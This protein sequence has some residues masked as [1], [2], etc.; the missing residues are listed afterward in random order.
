MNSDRLAPPP[1]RL[2][3]PVRHDAAKRQLE[4]VAAQRFRRFAGRWRLGA[5]AGLGIGLSVGGGVALASGVFSQQQ[6]GA[7]RQ[8][9]LAATVT[10]TRT[11]TATVYLG[12]PPY[13][14]NSV[15]LTLT[16]LNA[17][18]FRFPN[19]SSMGCSKSDVTSRN[20]CQSMEVE[21]LLPGKQSITISTSA[22]ATWTLEA[23]YVKEVVTP[24]ATNARGETY[25]VPNA[26]GFPDLVA[27]VFNDGKGQ[28]YAKWR[29]LN[30]AQ[31]G[32]G[33]PSTPAEAL[34]Q[35]KQRENTNVAVPVYKSDGT[36][37]IGVFLVG[38]RGPSTHTVPVASVKCSGPS[39]PQS[40]PISGLPGG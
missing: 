26:H 28:G 5:V 3:P 36:T 37:K 13:K 4:E 21:N 27:V 15:S 24:W 38:N 10:A 20:G 9:N 12:R 23:T 19:G 40:H 25:G 33:P 34:A 32:P 39:I 22:H 1:E 11:G 8:T 29:D 35:Q 16:G 31:E 17:G 14:A 7:P 6:P 30:C 2:L 18:S